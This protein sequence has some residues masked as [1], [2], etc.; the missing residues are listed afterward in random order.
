MQTIET[1]SH[2]GADGILRLNLPVNL[3]ETDVDI[4]VVVQPRNGT[5]NNGSGAKSW[6]PGFFDAVIGGWQGEILERPEQGEYEIR[7]GA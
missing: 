6:P 4:I 3:P 5:A 1:H 2:I 7:E